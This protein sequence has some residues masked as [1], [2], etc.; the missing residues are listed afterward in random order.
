[1]KF[2]WLSVVFSN[3]YATQSCFMTTLLAIDVLFFLTPRWAVF[4]RST[5][6]QFSAHGRSGL[7]P[8]F[9]LIFNR[10][11]EWIR[12]YWCLTA[13]VM[14]R[15]RSV[16]VC[17]LKSICLCF[18]T[19][20]LCRISPTPAVTPPP[21]PPPPRRLLLPLCP[22]LLCTPRRAPDSWNSPALQVQH[23]TYVIIIL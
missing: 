22:H 16:F 15:V 9:W 12:V 3:T 20:S 10:P 11:W 23:K 4:K 13:P 18:R 21:P 6:V 5:A 17:Y 1:M 8:G 19:T 2:V 14:S 7:Q